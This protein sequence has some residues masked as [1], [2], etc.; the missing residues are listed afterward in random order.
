MIKDKKIIIGISGVLN[1]GKDTVA[2][3]LNYIF[4]NGTAATFREWSIKCDIP[5]L[6]MNNVPC[7]HFADFNKFILSEFYNIPVECFYDRKYKD[8]LWY[9]FSTKMFINDEIVYKDKYFNISMVHLSGSSLNDLISRNNGK[10]CIKIRTLM[11]YFGTNIVRNQVGDE[12]WIGK[13]IRDAI[14]IANRHDICF[15]PDVRYNNEAEAIRRQNNSFVLRLDR[16]TGNF[17]DHSSE[18]LD[19]K[20]ANIDTVINNNDTKL[21]L[22]YNVVKFYNY[23]VSKT[24]N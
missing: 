12:I 18:E 1:S 13:T 8:E 10:V 14:R 20:D 6:L 9:S 11:Q 7:V 4:H 21:A 24:G 17:V 16:N 3:M 2:S 22:F 23:V 19:I 15:I 5:D